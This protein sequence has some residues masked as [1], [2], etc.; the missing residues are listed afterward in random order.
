MKIVQSLRIELPIPEADGDPLV[1][2][3]TNHGSLTIRV[4]IGER[5]HVITDHQAHLLGHAL[6]HAETFCKTGK[7]VEESEHPYTHRTGGGG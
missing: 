6:N 4:L 5:V 1:A 2:V 3:E 7:V